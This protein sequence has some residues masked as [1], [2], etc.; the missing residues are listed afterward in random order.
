M[1]AES[2]E[3]NQ[4]LDAPALAERIARTVDRIERRPIQLMEVCGTHTV[5]LFRS[6]VKSLLPEGLDLISGP[7]CPVCVTSQGYID[8]ACEL[9]KRPEVTICTYGDMMRVPG[10]LGSLEAMRSRGSRIQVVYSTRDA[11]R[12]AEQKPDQQI[13][14]L[15]V[16]FETTAPATAA[17]VL[18]AA[19]RGIENVS[20]LCGH[21][22]VIPAML[23]LLEDDEVA[24]DGFLCP[25]HVSVV[26]GS[27]AYEP[28]ARDA[29]KPCVVAG[30][31]PL[32]MLEAIARLVEQLRD[33]RAEVENV[34]EVAVSPQGNAV[35]R[36]MIDKVFEPAA[37]VW[38]A[39]G[40]LPGSGLELRQ[41]YRRYDAL[42]RFGVVMGPDVDPPGCLC[43]QVIQGKV[44][45]IECGLFGN[46][47][48]PL[49]PVGPC[50]VSSEGTCAAWYKYR[51]QP[52][53]Q[54][55]P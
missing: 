11:L 17:M 31:E 51:R 21:R 52:T 44:K 10:R 18:E 14:F 16:G 34:Y 55:T 40:S 6:G 37:A 23:T 43:G 26:I 30:F 4:R 28:I 25:G 47:C 42:E 32:D 38:R 48:T 36:Q 46:T 22:L 7:G 49:T 33:G 35:A 1:M 50:M 41:P 13:V 15:A 29:H 19:A 2:V 45:P 9:A 5:S 39:M 12:L 8:A 53:A 24:I 3:Q 27:E 54:G 20:I